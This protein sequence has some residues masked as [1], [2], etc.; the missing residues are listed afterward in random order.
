M[1]DIQ[2]IE[3]M[4]PVEQVNVK[5]PVVEDTGH[6]AIGSFAGFHYQYFYFILQLLKSKKNEEIGF[7]YLDDVNTIDGEKISYYQLKHTVSQAKSGAK[8]LTVCDPDFWKSI[9]VWL[10]IIEKQSQ[11]GVDLVSY[12]KDANY[13]LVTNKSAADNPICQM[14]DKY[15]I[16]GASIEDVKNLIENQYKVEEVDAVNPNKKE[17]MSKVKDYMKAAVASPYFPQLLLNLKIEYLSDEDLIQS[18]RDE[19]RNQLVPDGAL[20]EAMNSVIGNIGTE[21]FPQIQSGE[22][23]TITH[24]KVLEMLRRTIGQYRGERFKPDRN[25]K[26]P[27]FEN[28][29]NLT[30][31]KQLEAVDDI[32]SEEDIVEYTQTYVDYLQNEINAKQGHYYSMEDWE[33]LDV[34]ARRFWRQKFK[35]HYK[36]IDKACHKEIC[37]AASKLLNEIRDKELKLGDEYMDTYHSNGLYYVLSGDAKENY[38]VIGW[39]VNWEQIFGR[40]QNG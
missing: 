24:D 15:Q 1:K 40:K 35:F 17:M 27:N 32:T 21:L 3:K 13:C 9:H 8:N 11:K 28:M 5:I 25:F 31:I 26:I 19:I 10:D 16:K 30:F 37:Q 6:S 14:I 29:K 18:I 12:F 36:F 2:K 7:E 22:F 20:D 4:D 33:R 39:H 23:K 34:D 38:P